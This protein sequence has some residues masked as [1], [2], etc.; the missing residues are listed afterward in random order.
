V[1]VKQRS[2]LSQTYSL[3]LLAPALQGSACSASIY[4]GVAVPRTHC[5]SCCCKASSHS[6]PYFPTI[7]EKRYPT[8]SS[9]F[10]MVAIILP[11]H[12]GSRRSEYFLGS[13]DSKT[14]VLSNRNG[15][16]FPSERSAGLVVVCAAT[17]KWRLRC[18]LHLGLGA[19]CTDRRKS[20]VCS[21]ARRPAV[22]TAGRHANPARIER[23]HSACLPPSTDQASNR[24]TC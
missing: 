7:N 9:S 5:T 8:A 16:N 10:G 17:H 12:L 11:F 1:K 15:P 23:R 18:T 20:V 22:C 4:A 3:G 2:A 24:G 14:L 21:A 19:R 6:Q 13:S